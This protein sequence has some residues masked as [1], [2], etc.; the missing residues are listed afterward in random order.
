M[1]HEPQC[2]EGCGDCK[3]R[4][5]WKDKVILLE[6]LREVKLGGFSGREHCCLDL[7]Q[8]LLASAP[9]LERIILTARA[10]FEF[11]WLPVLMLAESLESSLPRCRGQWT[12]RRAT[13]DAAIISEYE[14]MPNLEMLA[15]NGT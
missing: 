12:A 15:L 14:W 11:E 6:H 7:V 1:K 4:G 3:L 5:S 10:S 2:D 9:A 8:L 13:N